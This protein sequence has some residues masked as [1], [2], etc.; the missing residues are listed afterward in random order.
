MF[1][2]YKK[3]IIMIGLI[4]LSGIVLMSQTPEVFPANQWSG[5]STIK[6][7]IY[8]IGNVGI[9]TTTTGSFKL[10]VEGKLGAR[11]IIVQNESWADYV[12]DDNYPLL[13][14]EKLEAFYKE[15]KR[16]PGIPSA[17]KVKNDGINVGQMNEKLLQKIEE[18][19]LYMVQL[20]KENAALKQRLDALEK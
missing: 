8:R 18:L 9:G 19:T 17:D 12:F 4:I 3:S 20:K 7:D 2:N 16:L 1:K 15:N 11:E 13:P 6:G 5:S 14:L 10:A